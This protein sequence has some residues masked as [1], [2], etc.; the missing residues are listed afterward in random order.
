MADD[1]E[2]RSE[3]GNYWTAPPQT[4]KRKQRVEYDFGDSSS[5]DDVEEEVCS[6]VAYDSNGEELPRLV[7]EKRRGAVAPD[8]GSLPKRGR[9]R[10]HATPSRQAEGSTSSERRSALLDKG[11]VRGCDGPSQL[12]VSRRATMPISRQ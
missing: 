4:P 3:L 8:I 6:D 10:A 11:W 1:A 5:D 9:V 12:M 7:R 2:L